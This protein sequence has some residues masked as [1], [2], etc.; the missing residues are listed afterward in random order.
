[1]AEIPMGDF[2]PIPMGDVLTHYAKEKGDAPAVTYPE[3]SLTWAELESRA[4]KL[5][6]LY[7]EHGVV[8]NDLVTF[9]LPNCL[10][11]HMAVF[12]VWK[13]GAVPHI[14][15]P[16]LTRREISEIV[17]LANPRIVLGINPNLV[18]G[19]TTLLPD[20]DTAGYSDAPLES[21]IAP[22]WRA[23]SSGGSTGRPKI[24][25][26]HNPALWGF[27]Y[28][29]FNFP[30][31]ECV[32]NPGPVYHSGPMSW[33]TIALLQGNHLVG[34]RK[35]D[36]V[37]LLS[38]IEEYRVSW[39]QLVPTMMHRIWKLG[40][41]ERNRYDL[42]SLKTV[43][44]MASHMPIWLKE[45]W[46]E[47]L[48]PERILELYG[49][50]EALGI[51]VIS[52][53]EWMTHKGSVGKAIAGE[54]RV[55]DDDGNECK[56]G[57]HGNVCFATP[58]GDEASYHYIGAQAVLIKS[59]WETLGDMGWKDE[60]GYLYLAERKADMVITGGANIYPAEVEA[61]LVRHPGV[62][63][64]VVIGLPHEDLGQIVHAII[65]PKA[66]W[67]EDLDEDAMRAFLE[68]RLVL[69]KTPRTYE[70]VTCS[71][72]DDAGKIRRPQLIAER[73]TGK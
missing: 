4:N 41:E 31:N 9:A 25:V 7:R 37:Q 69:Y 8:Q 18:D 62:E 12:A 17:E 46:I 22:Y 30:E 33:T 15:S 32:L 71:L 72:R 34:M 1:M 24:I 11:Y 29:L 67:Q 19:R 60:E 58:G 6:R 21:K 65:K 23:M 13:L 27:V 14:I 44:H 48:G 49:G 40:E 73:T 57:E 20:F 70:F 36:P 43:L 28:P 54:I 42:S 56:P 16:S 59:G 50:T 53:T 45:K 35:F 68:D 64:A 38:L 26:D 63:D 47:W 2:D 5:A 3:G 51:T 55:L 52:G 10:H 66:D 61:A 39:V